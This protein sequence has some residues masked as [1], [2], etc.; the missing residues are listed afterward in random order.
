M[1]DPVAL[2]SLPLPPLLVSPRPSLQV[3]PVT[4]FVRRHLP[5]DRGREG[6]L[7]GVVKWTG[8]DVSKQLWRGERKR[9]KERNY[10]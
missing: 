7:D 8:N 6:G 2:P 10:V 9:E 4:S 3:P 1:T 5:R